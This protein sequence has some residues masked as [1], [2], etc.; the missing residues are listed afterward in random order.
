MTDR[1]VKEFTTLTD[2]F[3]G[4]LDHIFI[5]KNFQVETSL[6]STSFGSSSI[7]LI[8]LSCFLPLSPPCSNGTCL[9]ECQSKDLTSILQTVSCLEMFR[10]ETILEVHMYASIARN[11]M[12]FNPGEV[13]SFF[14]IPKRSHGLHGLHHLPRT[15]KLIHLL[16][17]NKP[18][19][20][21]FLFKEDR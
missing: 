17:I 14:K 13:S 20:L 16:N 9:P 2:N 12:S 21:S 6:P 8:R 7:L 19:K 11:D 1:R 18:E 15:L 5:T 4:C 3:R 10:E